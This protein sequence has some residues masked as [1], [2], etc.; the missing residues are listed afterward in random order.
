MVA[1][2]YVA[3][4]LVS[5]VLILSGGF[6][7]ARWSTY[8][9]GLR[10]FAL[11]RNERSPLTQIVA[12]GLPIAEWATGVLLLGPLGLARW[13]SVSAALLFAAF[14]GL[15]SLE[16]RS[17]IA[18]CGCWGHTPMEIPKAS[19]LLRAGGILAMSLVA[20]GFLFSRSESLPILTRLSM[21]SLAV[22]F[23]LLL[24]EAP[25]IGRLLTVQAAMKHTA[26][27]HP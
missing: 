23:G 4:G 20:V 5:S 9:A 19:Y 16:D 27:S 12:I 3:V 2:G 15:L 25:T 14:V 6:K 1:F 21:A 13:A 22:P 24:L 8:V 11:F 10:S 7:F 18:N 26:R 17:F